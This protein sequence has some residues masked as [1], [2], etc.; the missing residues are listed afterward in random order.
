VAARDV[1]DAFDTVGEEGWFSDFP[2]KDEQELDHATSAANPRSHFRPDVE[3]MRT[4]SA[5]GH[6]F[7]WASGERRLSAGSG[8][9]TPA[10][11]MC[12]SR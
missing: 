9:A 1:A 5:R 6:S 11:V 2:D 3:T 10:A 8:L 7:Q 4:E 12:A